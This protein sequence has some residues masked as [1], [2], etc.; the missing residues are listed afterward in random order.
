LQAVTL[1]YHITKDWNGTNIIPFTKYADFIQRTYKKTLLPD[2]KS[3]PPSYNPKGR[4]HKGPT[5]R[6]SWRTE[7]HRVSRDE[8]TTEYFNTKTVTYQGRSW[9]LLDLLHE[10]TLP[11]YSAKSNNPTG[12]MTFFYNNKW[13][14]TKRVRGIN[15]Q[16]IGGH[17]MSF[18]NY[19][20]RKLISR[21]LLD[22]TKVVDRETLF[23]QPPQ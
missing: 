18:S 3:Y 19:S 12:L 2:L 21:S 14:R 9:N 10:G 5:L 16:S 15:P 11:G 20:M 22:A 4:R 6:A 7:S 1:K 17:D 8:V 23:W 13:I